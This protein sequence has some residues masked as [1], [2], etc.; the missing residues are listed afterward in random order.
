MTS[1]APAARAYRRLS[2]DERRAQLLTA[3][4]ALF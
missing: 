3:A 4:L 2:V 1:P